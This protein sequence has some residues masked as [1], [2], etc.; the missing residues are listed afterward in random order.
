MRCPTPAVHQQHSGGGGLWL[1]SPAPFSMLYPRPQPGPTPLSYP[2]TT[3]SSGAMADGHGYGSWWDRTPLQP[4]IDAPPRL[5]ALRTSGSGSFPDVVW[6]QADHAQAAL[7][8]Q[9]PDSAKSARMAWHLLNSRAVGQREPTAADDAFSGLHRLQ[10]WLSDASTTSHACPQH[11]QLGQ[12]VQPVQHAAVSPTHQPRMYGWSADQMPDTAP[13]AALLPTGTGQ[14]RKA[15]EQQVF[16]DQVDNMDSALL[17]ALYPD[18]PTAVAAFE[19]D[20]ASSGGSAAHAGEQHLQLGDAASMAFA[21]PPAAAAA[22]AA[23]F[24]QQLL[25]AAAVAGMQRPKK[26]KTG[27]ASS[28]SRAVHRAPVPHAAHGPAPAAAPAAAPM[29]ESGYQIEQVVWGKF[30]AWPWWPATVSPSAPLL[31][32]AIHACMTIAFRLCSQK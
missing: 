10:T 16:A 20:W 2:P 22:A 6:Q 23:A 9:S 26:R 24:D 4:H 3:G 25:A 30:G 7:D 17:E 11:V 15:E 8:A 28:S 32:P 29:Q 1:H 13:N 31:T 5:P 27:H 18:L 12:P 19:G 14:K 21:Q